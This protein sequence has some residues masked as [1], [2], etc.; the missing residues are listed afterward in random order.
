MT[1]KPFKEGDR[2]EI[3]GGVFGDVLEVTMTYV[4]IRTIKEEVVHVSNPQVIGNKIIN[5]SGYLQSYFIQM[6]H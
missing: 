1:W 5:Y 4:K 2:V 3:G 6:L